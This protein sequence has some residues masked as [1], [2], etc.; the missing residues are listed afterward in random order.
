MPRD[1]AREVP[2]TGWRL[3]THVVIVASVLLLGAVAY[4][5]LRSCNEASGGLFDDGG[6]QACDPGRGAIA[7]RAVV[8]WLVFVLVVAAYRGVTSRQESGTHQSPVVE[9]P[10][11]V[12]RLEVLAK[13]HQS[14]SLTDEEFDEE[15]RRLLASD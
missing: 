11:R 5:L 1:E 14:G 9:R 15:K 8:V 2:S 13:L 10:D 7:G 3:S 6:G 12:A 4:D